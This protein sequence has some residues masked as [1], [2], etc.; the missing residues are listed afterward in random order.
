MSSEQL[1]GQMGLPVLSPNST[2]PDMLPSGLVTEAEARDPF[3]EKYGGWIV[4]GFIVGFGV[5]IIALNLAGQ[6]PGQSFVLKGA[7]DILQTAGQWIGFWFCIRIAW[8]LRTVATALRRAAMRMEASQS[9][10]RASIRSVLA[11]ISSARR[12]G[13]AWGCLAI[14]IACYGT[15]GIIWTS[16]DIRMPTAQ[17]P[18]P[19]LY[20]VGYVAA[21][22]FFVIGMI[23]LARRNATTAGRFRLLL[24][25]L[26]V[27]GT[28]LSLS[29][30][31]LLAPSIAG[32]SNSPSP[33][34]SFLA[35]YFPAGDLL[36]IAVG[37][38]LFFTLSTRSLQPVLVRVVVGL[39]C[40]ATA[41]S[42][43]GYFNLTSGFNTGT[44]LD[45]LWPTSL[46]LVGL[47][48]IEYPR[49]IVREQQEGGASAALPATTLS[50]L[51]ST[52]QSVIPYTLV[53]GTGVVLLLVIAP[54]GR[55]DLIQAG[56][57]ALLLVLIISVRQLL[58]ILENERLNAQTRGELVI[59][60]RELQVTRREADEATRDAA[61]KQ[62]LQE[63]I[64]ML[65][66]VHTR[67]SSG[68]LRA[69]ASVDVGPLLPIAQSL[70]LMLDR[71]RATT[72]RAVAYD[73]LISDCRALQGLVDQ[74]GQDVPMEIQRIAIPSTSE[75]Q[76]VVMGVFRLQH[77]HANRLRRLR[78]ALEM[79]RSPLQQ[80][81]AALVQGTSA[82]PEQQRSQ[83]IARVE[84][85][86]AKW[87][88]VRAQAD[89]ILNVLD[90]SVPQARP[91][92]NQQATPFNR[93]AS[94]LHD[95]RP[96]RPQS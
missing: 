6:A 66:Q 40:L 20:D 53:L 34:A 22:P 39:A 80:M 62:E 60:R 21:Y 10:S 77:V 67:V 51:G 86:E 78:A 35:I 17:V 55:N 95:A 84:D 75:I 72:Q 87:S 58:T 48:A 5:L 30:F 28:A 14:G 42:L 94:N 54:R 90:G 23:L 65:Q 31:F 27:I 44:L 59:S 16:Y 12:A 26:S 82:S 46:L 83:L 73:R 43:L 45:L 96:F 93:P 29:W 18:Y 49:S 37:A 7:S 13:L 19:G 81:H 89:T 56:V 74:L 47:A 50:R 8:R 32:L 92:V 71:L 64:R 57:I 76:P 61:E 52:L 68:D 88:N 4:V 36:L 24:D 2:A 9:V 11:T 3:L 79:M 1:Q 85:L 25:A 70:N 38:F 91:V 69:R 33:L 63:G 41:D 15:A